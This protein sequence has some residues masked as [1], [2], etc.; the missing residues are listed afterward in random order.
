M[1][2]IKKLLIILFYILN[3]VIFSFA[4]PV[5]SQVKHTEVNDITIAYESFGDDNEETILL[6]H[7]LGAQLTDWPDE[8]CDELVSRGYR[9]IRFDNR[10]IGQSTHADSLGRPD[11]EAIGEAAGTGSP[12]PLPYSLKDMA[13]DAVGLLDGLGIEEVHIAGASMGGGI[14]QIIA[15]HHPEKVQ[16]LTMF[17]SDTG[18]PEMPGPSEE[19]LAMPPA[20]PAGSDIEEIVEREF[21]IQKTIA[22]PGYPAD[23]NLMR[24]N[25]RR[26]AERS[27]NPIAVERQAAAVMFAGDRREQ[28][29]KLD[30]P[31]V[32]LHGSADL[33]VP[34]ENGKDLAENI[35]GAKLRIIEGLG[36]DLPSELIGEFA[37]AITSAAKRAEKNGNK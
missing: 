20:P 29:Q 27:Y 16:S 5:Y 15:I 13:E 17:F 21:E 7:G 24:K 1:Y 33:L 11:W 22:S 6:I 14:A 3:A 32:V 2:Q 19:V 12:V 37:D 25:I 23:E 34:V 36:H 4:A 10:D 28:L 30:V 8:F 9:V 35:P 31:T 18:N 26:N